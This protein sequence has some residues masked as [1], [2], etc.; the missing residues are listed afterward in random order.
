MI[1]NNQSGRSMIEMLGVL[2]IIGVLSVGGIAG[3]TKAMSKYKINKCLSQIANIQM[4]IGTLYAQQKNYAGIN[5][6]N[7]SGDGCNVLKKAKIVP[8][9]MWKNNKLVNPF[10]GNVSIQSV[11]YDGEADAAFSI[12]YDGIPEDAAIYFGMNKENAND[13][14][15]MNIKLN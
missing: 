9:E 2:A 1:K 11:E 12:S 5:C 14:N 10:G 13:Q 3:Y 15:L 6:V 4:G 8:E 7:G